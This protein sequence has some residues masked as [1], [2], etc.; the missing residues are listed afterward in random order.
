MFKL[1]VCGH[2]GYVGN[3]FFSNYQKSDCQ[4]IGADLES[5]NN[6][7]EYNVDFRK[8][9]EVKDLLNIVRPDYI[10]NFIGINKSNSFKKYLDINVSTLNNILE[11]LIDLRIKPQKI[12]HTSSSAVYGNQYIFVDESTKLNPLTLYGLSKKISESVCQYYI[13]KGLEIIVTRPSNIIGKNM[14]S[15]F[16]LP[17]IIKKVLVSRKSDVNVIDLGNL[18]IKRDFIDISDVFDSYKLIIEKGVKPVY[19]I[20]YG[21]STSLLECIKFVFQC[22]DYYPTLSHN[23]ID[24]FEV[25]DLIPSNMNIKSLGFFPKKDIVITIKEIITELDFEIKF[26]KQ[27]FR[28]M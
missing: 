24:D 17:K 11:S 22:L 10:I 3:Y 20:S 18:N 21:N 6:S 13:K 27:A 28:H 2:R 26:S 14:D 19:N 16:V 4:I 12:I 25:T 15:S 8:Y 7:F 23:A 5:D 9:D 1:L